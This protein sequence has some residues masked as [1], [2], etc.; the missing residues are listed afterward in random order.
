MVYRVVNKILKANGWNVV[1]VKGSHF[2]YKHP[3]RNICVTV[4]NHGNKDISKF[5]MGKLEES[6]GLSFS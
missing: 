5:V 4:P 2:Q 3:D 6:T 1:R